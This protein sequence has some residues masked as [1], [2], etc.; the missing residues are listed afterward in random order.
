MKKWVYGQKKKY[1][2]ISLSDILGVLIDRGYKIIIYDNWNIQKGWDR[3]K[4]IYG[5]QLPYFCE[6]AK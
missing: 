3:K 5:S 2:P 1:S 6:Q 4:W